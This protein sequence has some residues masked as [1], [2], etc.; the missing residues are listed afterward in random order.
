MLFENYFD[1]I[2][3]FC[4]WFKICDLLIDEEMDLDECLMCLI[5]EQIGIFENVKKVFW[6]EILI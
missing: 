4:N 3:V 6:E 2:E 1:N 5:E